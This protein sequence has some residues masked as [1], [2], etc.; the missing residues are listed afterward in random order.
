MFPNP[1]ASRPAAGSG[2][3]RRS[4]R[5]E[6]RLRWYQLVYR[7]IYR[8]GLIIWRR[9]AP[10]A[11]LVALVQGP[12][13]MEAGR[14]LDLGCGTGT[15]TIYLARH[16]WDVTAVDM[17]P[18]ALAIARDSAIAA[19]VTPRFI[20]GDVTRLDEL[21]VGTG[22]TLL[23]DFGCFHTLPDDRRT[24]YVTAVSDAAAPGATLLLYGFRRPP[25]AAPLHAGMTADEVR[26]RFS[27]AGWE[28]V[29]AE[30]S[31]I[32]PVMAPRADDL[33]ELWRYQLRRTAS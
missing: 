15:D 18:K 30:R 14:A 23:V 12:S 4:R 22:Y 17:V 25:K 24:A 6:D 20:L 29:E 33:F 8:V 16:G 9:A 5:G 3:A 10:P 13:A 1:P 26:Q 21:D 32:K 28:L 27:T 31:H 11:E 19:G 2:G 7:L